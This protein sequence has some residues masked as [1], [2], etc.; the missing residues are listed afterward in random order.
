MES[1]NLRKTAPAFQVLWE[2]LSRQLNK[3]D[4]ANLFSENE[5]E[6]FYQKISRQFS[7]FS[8]C[9]SYALVLSLRIQIF[10][11]PIWMYGKKKYWF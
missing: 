7:F 11:S 1:F 10:F 3:L 5:L 4:L 2:Y 8:L 6:T 9:I